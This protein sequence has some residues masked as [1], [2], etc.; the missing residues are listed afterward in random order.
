MDSLPILLHSTIQI[1][2]LIKTHGQKK[3]KVEMTTKKRIDWQEEDGDKKEWHHINMRYI[4]ND[5]NV[6]INDDDDGDP[7]FQY[8]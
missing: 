3:A 1:D 7:I 2:S 8:C 4:T 6:A 5:A